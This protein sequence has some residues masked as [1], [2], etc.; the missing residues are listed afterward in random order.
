MTRPEFITER[1]WRDHMAAVVEIV[2]EPSGAIVVCDTLAHCIACDDG[3]AEE[4]AGIV[5]ALWRGEF[6][7]IGG[8]AAEGFT[9]RPAPVAAQRFAAA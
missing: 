6:Y 5:T 7:Q 3:L 4:A 8:G 1:D 9:I 2:H